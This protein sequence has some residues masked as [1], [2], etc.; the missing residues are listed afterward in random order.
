[1]HS[2]EDSRTVDRWV[3]AR[4]AAAPTVAAGNDELELVVADASWRLLFCR[5][6]AVTVAFATA[7]RKA[8]VS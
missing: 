2:A 7:V 8:V 6:G 1:M 3:S 4:L 5:D